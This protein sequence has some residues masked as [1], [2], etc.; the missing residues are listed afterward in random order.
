MTF[1]TFTVSGSHHYCWVPEYFLTW[2][3]SPIRLPSSSWQPQVCFLSPWICLLLDCSHKPYNTRPYCV[4]LLSVS[5]MFL[6]LILFVAGV[7]PSFL[8]MAEKFPFLGYTTFHLS[9]HPW[10]GIYVGSALGLL[11][12]V[13]SLVFSC[14][15]LF[16]EQVGMTLWGRESSVARHDCF[17]P[18][19]STSGLP[20]G[21]WGPV[22]TVLGGQDS[23]WGER[24]TWANARCQHGSWLLGSTHAS[25]SERIGSKGRA[26]ECALHCQFSHASFLIFLKERKR[27]GGREMRGAMM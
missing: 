22:C 27:A 11:R 3:G 9:G 19:D 24:G 23:V 2:K 21:C 20:P 13:S 10:M 18:A 25:S 16:W 7:S 8:F 14:L 4:W 6:R 15:V 26:Q 12:R 1:S 5:I 17:R